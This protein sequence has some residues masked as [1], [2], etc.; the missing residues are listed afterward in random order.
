[1]FRILEVDCHYHKYYI[2]RKIPRALLVTYKAYGC[3]RPSP[4]YPNTI[5]SVW[6][7]EQISCES[8]AISSPQL[9]QC[10][11]LQQWCAIGISVVILF[12]CSAFPLVTEAHLTGR[13]R[14][15]FDN[16]SVVLTHGAFIYCVEGGFLSFHTTV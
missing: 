4:L 5:M 16:L 10:A 3:Y 7:G 1:M 8:C 14:T 2:P 6:Q 12:E 13:L 9:R 11:M 15:E